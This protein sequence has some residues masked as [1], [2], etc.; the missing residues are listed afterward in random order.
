M[1][2][3]S[4]VIP[5][6][7]EAENL[8]ILVR[9]LSD[10]LCTAGMEYEIVVVDDN[11]PDATRVVCDELQRQY[12]VHLLV[13]EHERG[14]SSAVIAG[15]ERATSEI[16]VVMDADLSHPPEKIPEMVEALNDATVDF[17]IGSR[18]VQGGST[19]EE[20]GLLR[21]L[22]S[23][24]ATLLARPLT[25][26]SDPM[27]G[28][29]AL[30]RSRFEAVAERLDPIGYKIGLEL[31]VKSRC[32]NIIEIPI[33]FRDRMHGQS[34]LNLKEQLNYLRHLRRL[35]NFRYGAGAR[36]FQFAAVGLSGMIVDLLAFW[37][38]LKV[39]SLPIARALAI[40]VAMS[41][42]FLL[43]R[44]ITFSYAREGSWLR[45]YLGYCASCLV[46]AALNWT[47]SVALCTYSAF[48]AERQLAAAFIGVLAGTAANFLL[49]LHVVFRA[50]STK[51][52]GRP[53][54]STNDGSDDHRDTR[55]GEAPKATHNDDPARQTAW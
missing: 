36:F 8:P 22:N 28:F 41:W 46:G 26:A 55:Q 43:N 29:F 13:R 35:Y 30:R 48:F 32:R 18:Y 23:K 19:T 12:A 27:A 14:L 45:Q 53:I 52:H 11:S 31:I 42:T 15:I 2:K 5:T 21:W 54:E 38:L 6:Y 24:V 40:T 4:V 34:K 3:V 1:P 7:C 17:V 9:R 51:R 39:L 44:N 20:W 37:L 49:C 47:T 10:A 25:R 16:V 33:R 50:G